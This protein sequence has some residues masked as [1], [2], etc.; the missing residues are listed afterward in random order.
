[1]LKEEQ[2]FFVLKIAAA[3]QVLPILCEDFKGKNPVQILGR[4]FVRIRWKAADL[5][6]EAGCHFQEQM[7]RQGGFSK[8]LAELAVHLLCLVAASSGHGQ[9]EE[10]GIVGE[11]G[12]PV[13][14]QNRLVHGLTVNQDIYVAPVKTD[15][16]LIAAK[17]KGYAFGNRKAV[18]VLFAEKAAAPRNAV[19]KFLRAILQKR[20]ACFGMAGRIERGIEPV[21][22][23][24]PERKRQWHRWQGSFFILG[25]QLGTAFSAQR[26]YGQLNDF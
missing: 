6:G 14:I 10:K 7:G 21:S 17:G 25:K 16:Q 11:V 1:M 24:G 12:Q 5:I 22:Q 9:Q 18:A 26:L 2:G 3:V 4:G 19:R 8:A 23:E 20:L 13:I 15:L